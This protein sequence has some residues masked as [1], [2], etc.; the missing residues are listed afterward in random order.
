MRYFQA[1][2]LK[3]EEGPL[4]TVWARGNCLIRLTQI[5]HCKWIRMQMSENKNDQLK[6]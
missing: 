2:A 1:G 3:N 4:K 5:H 6:E